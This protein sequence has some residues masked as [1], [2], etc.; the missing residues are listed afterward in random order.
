[1]LDPGACKT[2]RAFI[3]VYARSGFD[4]PPGVAHQC[5]HQARSDNSADSRTD[6]FALSR[7]LLPF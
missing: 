7:T 5:Q 2:K 4:V 6:P 3:W 1:M